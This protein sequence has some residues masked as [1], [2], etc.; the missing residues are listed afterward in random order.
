MTPPANHSPGQRARLRLIATTDLHMHLTAYDYAG[1]RPVRGGAL[2]RLATLVHTARA[3]AEA[4][5]RALLLL[6]NGDSM[7]G[8]PMGDMAAVATEGL[9][10]P[11]MHAFGIMGYDAIGLGNHDFN[12]GLGALDAA[13]ADAPCPVI[14]SNLHRIRPGILP[15]VS[16]DT[17]LDCALP[18]RDP[19]ETLKIG[20]LS[21]LPPQ[22]VR[23]DAHLLEGHLRVDDILCSA[24]T[25]VSRLR[26]KGCDL[27]VALAHSGLGPVH[28][29]PGMENAVIPLAALDGIDVV[30][31]GHTHQNLPGDDH[32]GFAETDARA[33]SVHGKPVMMPGSAGSHLGVADIDL[34]RHA[35]GRWTLAGFA[36]ELRPTSEIGPDGA[37]RPMV[38][39]DPAV[40]EALAPY[41]T[42]TLAAMA[43]PVGH[44]DRPMHTFFS[45]L[46]PD[47]ALARLA[48]SQAAA[49]RP[50]LAGTAAQDL[51]IVSAVAPAK[52][53]GRGGADHFSDVPAGV[54]NA[55]HIADLCPFP[56]D[57]QAV[58]LR[59][60]QLVEWLEMSASLF[61]RISPGAR[62]VALTDPDVP[63]H[64]FDVLH[65][66]R[67]QIDLTR[68]ARYQPNGQLRPDADRRITSVTWMGMPLDPEQRFVV[69]LNSYR[70]AG[71][72]DV[73]ALRGAEHIS[74]PRLPLRDVL[75][76]YLAGESTSDP[77]DAAPPSWRF[78]PVPD[79]R[80]VALTSPAATAHL[81][82][83]AGRGITT[84]GVDANG[85]LRLLVP[86]D[87]G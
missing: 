7:Q 1:G 60:R 74:I 66:L 29:L 72:G 50:L 61:N 17:I 4:E 31:A 27:I 83:L 53:G 58:V 15:G 78:A 87:R 85:F 6:D 14:S 65:G 70:A 49:L 48:A 35:D 11:L 18:G 67:Y 40:S 3:E 38:A 24:H 8:T 34:E 22:T 21:F 77:L 33:G 44:S 84:D 5:D 73:A 79:A 51:P 9:P 26:D 36:I 52:C 19:G 42:A 55:R 82:E 41:H 12:F 81:A 43:R 56:N 62:D 68:P 46:Q 2:T 76:R 63:A 39:E 20:V 28:A 30:I 75:G 64:N 47:R 10:H 23:W 69:A 54:L 59:G 25:G 80:V 71:G 32:L 16:L 13:L 57:L 45:L 37:V 86:L